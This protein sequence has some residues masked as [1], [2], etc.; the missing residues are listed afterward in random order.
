MVERQ[1]FFQNRKEFGFYTEGEHAGCI[2][3]V[4]QMHA[5]YLA[6]EFSEAECTIVDRHLLACRRCENAWDAR[7]SLLEESFPPLKRK[8][9]EEDQ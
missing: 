1:G 3:G 4:D 7:T 2:Y 5:I 6:G 9:R 8:H